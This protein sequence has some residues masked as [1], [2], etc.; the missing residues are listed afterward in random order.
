MSHV[1]LKRL[2]ESWE[3]KWCCE[4][5]PFELRMGIEVGSTGSFYSLERPTLGYGCRVDSIADEVTPSAWTIRSKVFLPEAAFLVT[6]VGEV[7]TTR[8][9]RRIEIEATGDSELMDCVLRFVFH[10]A[11]VIETWIGERTI[12]HCSANR[13]HQYSMTDV[14]IIHAS[15]S[16]LKFASTVDCLPQGMKPVVYLRDERG[17]WVMH[18]RILA[19]QPSKYVFK[20]CHRFFNRP[21][22]DLIQRAVFGLKWLRD[23]LLYVRERLSQRIP[24]QVNGA[25]LLRRGDKI[26]F[27]VNW[28]W[29]VRS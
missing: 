14:R 25:V 11:E 15:G 4:E 17:Q 7:G 19:T 10:S 8:A 16:S 5:M 26:G 6:E 18:F 20:G 29:D 12:K 3:F 22:P 1:R 21:F 13:Y 23:G 27:T 24:F 9:C 2:G 28:E